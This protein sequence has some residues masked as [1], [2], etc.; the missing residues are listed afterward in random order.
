MPDEET[1]EQMAVRVQAEIDALSPI[2]YYRWRRHSFVQM[3]KRWR[4][5]K[6]QPVQ[7]VF[8]RH[9][10]EQMAALRVARTSGTRPEYMPLK[11]PDE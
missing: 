11:W 6:P 9:L 1:D 10:Q 4:K 8:L 2:Q 3:A 5:I 7:R